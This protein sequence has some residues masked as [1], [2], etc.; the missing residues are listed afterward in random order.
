MVELLRR[1]FGERAAAAL[2][3]PFVLGDRQLL[4]SI[5]ET[6][7]VENAEIR[8]EVGTARFPSLASWI[9]TDIRGWTLADM[10]DDDQ[11]DQLQREA[12]TALQSF[13]TVDGTVEF[14]APAHIVTATR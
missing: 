13:V 6:A 1:L 12:Q 9:Y 2:D 11:F 7:G 8:T 3:A 5:F 4:R 10:L 14:A